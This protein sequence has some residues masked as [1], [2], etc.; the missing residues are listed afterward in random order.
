M[1]FKAYYRG[2]F[3]MIPGISWNGNNNDPGNVYH[4]FSYEDIPWSFA[5][6]RTLIPGGTYSEGEKYSVGMFADE[7]NAEAGLSCSLIPDSLFR[8]HRLIVPEEEMPKRV[9]IKE[10]GISPGRSHTLE[11]A[12]GEKFTVSAWLVIQ[13]LADPKRGYRNF[14][15]AAWRHS[16]KDTRPLHT[17]NELWDYG[18]RFTKESL[19]DPEEHMF[20]LALLY[21]EDMQEW[22]QAGGFSVGW[23][24]RNL[25]L[26]NGLIND[27]L[28][29]GDTSSLKMALSCLD[30]WVDR[31]NPDHLRAN[32]S[33]MDDPFQPFF[34]L[35]EDA[36]RLSGGATGFLNAFVNLKA[37]NRDASKFLD[38]GLKICD[39]A[40]DSQTSEG[41]F[42]SSVCRRGSTGASLIDPLLTAFDI[43]GNPAYLTGAKRAMNYYNDMFYQDGYLWGG[44]LDTRS[45]DKESV[46]PFLSGNIRLYELTG[47]SFYLARAEDAAYYLAAWQIAQ[48]IPN[49]P[50]SALDQI[51]Y[52]SFGGTSVATVHMCADNYALSM[53]PWLLKLARYAGNKIWEE[54]AIAIWNYSTQGISDG[55]LALQGLAPRPVGSAD[56]T[57]NYTDWGY[58]FAAQGMDRDHPRGAGSCWLV[59]WMHAMRFTILSDEQLFKHIEQW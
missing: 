30:A 51:D 48:S 27:Y 24:G 29:K 45:I 50:G 19:W 14:L 31:V 49:V 53:V 28:R 6:H 3:T 17:V 38:I 44:A 22:S 54:R 34:G 52:E 16:F 21:N 12:P 42:E 43:S 11:L 23:C 25:E 40:L 8:I 13:P 7:V 10:W 47:E 37:C 32:Q 46:K 5:S 59:G 18:I 20:H 15:D 56:E 1:D 55:D 57:L 39:A 36:I 9:L 35:A 2:R 33:E 41:R 58:I 4:G 26:A